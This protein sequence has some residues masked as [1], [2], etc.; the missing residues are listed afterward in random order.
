MGIVLIITNQLKNTEGS[1][2][3]RGTRIADVNIELSTSTKHA[4]VQYN[5]QLTNNQPCKRTNN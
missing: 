3:T 5:Y 4:M 2:Q 1:Y